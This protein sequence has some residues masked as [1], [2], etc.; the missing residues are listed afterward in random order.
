MFE[1]R[2]ELAMTQEAD[3]LSFDVGHVDMLIATPDGF[4]PAAEAAPGIS[5]ASR[6]GQRDVHP[7]T[8]DLGGC[9][10]EPT[11]PPPEG[12]PGRRLASGHRPVGEIADHHRRLAAPIGGDPT[13]E[14]RSIR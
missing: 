13:S 12:A 3:D 11:G 1:D 4:G 10:S 2:R 14:K 5:G 6:D 7:L 8:T 9:R